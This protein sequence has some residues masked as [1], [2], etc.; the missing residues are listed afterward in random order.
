MVNWAKPESVD[1]DVLDME[2]LTN[3]TAYMHLTKA[4]LPYLQKALKETSLIF[5]TS[6]LAL[7]PIVHCPNYCSSTAALHHTILVMREQLRGSKVEIIELLSPAVQTELH[8]FETGEKG[9]AV[10]MP[11]ADFVEEAFEGL[12][13]E[14][15]EQIAVENVKDKYG[16][17]EW[18]QDRQ[19][20]FRELNAFMLQ[21]YA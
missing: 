18:E 14:E 21:R 16:I 11:L 9:K 19:K 12:C 5:T 15:N 6:G 4:F 8:D 10:G 20:N 3:Y 13:R 1:V 17:D 7:V 2:T